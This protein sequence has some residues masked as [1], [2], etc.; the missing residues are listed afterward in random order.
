V[1]S[2]PATLP[3]GH[4][5]T[6]RPV[7]VQAVLDL[8]G[9]VQQPSY[10]GGPATLAEAALAAVRGWAAEPV[11]LNGAPMPTAVILAVRFR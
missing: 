6:D 10:S 9:A 7:R 2:P 4:P 3:A 11:R 5:A 8:D 1:A